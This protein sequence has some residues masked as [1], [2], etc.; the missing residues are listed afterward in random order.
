MITLTSLHAPNARI[1]NLEGLQYA[2]NL[3]SLDISA[4]SITDFSPLKSLGAL[5]TITAH[6]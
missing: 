5:D 2:K 3:T 6:P 4:N 1:T